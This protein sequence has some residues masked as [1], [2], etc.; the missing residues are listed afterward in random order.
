MNK[1][2]IRFNTQHGDSELVWRVFENDTEHLVRGLRITVPVSDIVTDKNGITKWNI[3]CEGTM[4]V[5]DG[6]AVIT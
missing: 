4:R 5:I 1:Y 6:V 3:Y 2:Y